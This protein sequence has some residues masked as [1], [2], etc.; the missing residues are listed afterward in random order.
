MN[1]RPRPTVAV[2]AVLLSLGGCGGGGSG[3]DGGLPPT[4][5]TNGTNGSNGTAGGGTQTP[6]PTQEPAKEADFSNQA[7]LTSPLTYPPTSPVTYLFHTGGLV[8]VDP[9]NTLRT[10]TLSNQPL[11]VHTATV[12]RYIP[13][14]NTVTDIRDAAQVY[15]RNGKIWKIESNVLNTPMARQVSYESSAS[16]DCGSQP[17]NALTNKV[18]DV[19]IVYQTPGPDGDCKQTDDNVWRMVSLGMTPSSAPQPAKPV[20]MSF[21]DPDTGLAAG[22]LGSVDKQIYVYDADFGTATLLSTF[23]TSVAA[24]K[25]GSIA[26]TIVR[27]DDAVHAFDYKTRTLSPVLHLLSLDEQSQRAYA[28]DGKTVWLYE[29]GGFYRIDYVDAKPSLKIGQDPAPAGARI[30]V[31]SAGDRLVYWWI[32][33]GMADIPPLLTIKSIPKAGGAPK[34]LASRII[35]LNG[36]VAA[37]NRIYFNTWD[38]GPVAWTMLA[39]GSQPQS[40]SGAAWAQTVYRPEYSLTQAQQ[41]SVM[42][43]MEGYKGAGSQFGGGLLTAYHAHEFRRLAKIGQI[44]EDVLYFT[45]GRVSGSYVLAAAFQRPK[46]KGEAVRTDMYLLNLFKSYSLERLTDTPDVNEMPVS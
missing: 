1:T 35:Y 13:E 5:G 7:P 39:D 21:H 43:L 20:F 26:A 2:L 38:N 46:A 41:P 9:R 14:S 15:M 45:M 4:T 6:A 37:G 23:Q 36:I 11:P 31:V 29:G 24:W 40:K 16:E 18:S 42:V 10:F 32:E 34:T 17:G 44:P 25:I 22:W 8:A 19:R 3:N 33:P 30:G 28:A 27:V 12:A